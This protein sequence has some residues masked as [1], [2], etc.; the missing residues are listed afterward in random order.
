MHSL[1]LPDS[2][3]FIIDDSVVLSF[4]AMSENPKTVSWRTKTWEEE[5]FTCSKN[6]RAANGDNVDTPPCSKDAAIFPNPSVQ[7]YIP[8]HTYVDAISVTGPDGT[9]TECKCHTYNA[10]AM[11]SS[12]PLTISTQL[13]V[14]AWIPATISTF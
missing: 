12:M 1:L 4:A 14:T 10:A 3:E 9:L 5:S 2:G 7:V 6:W 13:H 8:W 11:A